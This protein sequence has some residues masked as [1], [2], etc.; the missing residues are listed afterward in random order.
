MVRARLSCLVLPAILFT[1]SAFLFSAQEPF[2]NTRPPGRDPDVA[3]NPGAENIYVPPMPGRPFTG[4]S[5]VTW[6]S[7]DGSSSH[8]A[9]MSMLARDSSGKLYFESRRRVG[10]SGEIQPRWNFIMI[11]PQ[12]KT[13]TTCYVSTKTCRINAF[14]RTVYADS[15]GAEDLPRAA[16]M[17]KVSLGTNVIDAL[18]LEGTRE[19][20]SVAQGAYNNSQPLVITRDVWH[21]Q[22]LALDVEVVKTDPRSGKFDRKLEILSRNDPDPEYFS[23]PSDY[24]SVDNRP[25]NAKRSTPQQ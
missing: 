5:E 2:S 6:T 16:T 10:A 21:S 1:A 23:I 8:F 25:L 17:E 24:T 12:E 3:A 18:I 4:K 9:F 22:E 7:P 20:T 11:D 14:R 19:I 13:R 15:E